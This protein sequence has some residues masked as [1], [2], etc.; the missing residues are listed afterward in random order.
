[1]CISTDLQLP[2]EVWLAEDWFLISSYHKRHGGFLRLSDYCAAL[3]ALSTNPMDTTERAF[4]RNERV[5]NRSTSHSA[6]TSAHIT[7]DSGHVVAL[8]QGSVVR[9]KRFNRE[10]G[11]VKAAA[12]DDLFLRPLH[13]PDSQPSAGYGASG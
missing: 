4:H 9:S 7:P 2:L 1:M 3:D 5:E 6:W 13:G 11:I 10:S 8:W 12:D